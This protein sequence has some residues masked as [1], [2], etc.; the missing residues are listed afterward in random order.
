MG[1]QGHAPSR[2]HRG[3]AIFLPFLASGATCTPQ[4]HGPPSSKPAAWH[5][6]N[7]SDS[8]SLP[9]S[10]LMGTLE[11]SLGPSRR[12]R[13]ISPSQDSESH[14]QSPFCLVGSH[15]IGCGDGT[16]TSLGEGWRDYSVYRSTYSVSSP[17]QGSAGDT[18]VTAPAFPPGAH[19]PVGRQ[20]CPQTVTPAVVRAGMG[21]P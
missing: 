21:P 15:V 8:Y 14:L 18:V 13:I 17:V 9:S 20:S 4:A 3:K 11:M 10:S 2:G 12:S 19:S 7:S 5:V 6:E 16:W 1:Q